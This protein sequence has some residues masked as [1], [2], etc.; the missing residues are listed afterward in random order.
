VILQQYKSFPTKSTPLSCN[1]SAHNCVA[2]LVQ[3][4][5]H[6]SLFL[7]LLL[8]PHHLHC[9]AVRCLAFRR[10]LAT[11]IDMDIHA[12]CYL[13]P[14][15]RYFPFQPATELS[16][17][18]V[19]RMRLTEPDSRCSH[20]ITILSLLL[21]TKLWPCTLPCPLT[22][23]CSTLPPLCTCNSLCPHAGPPQA[24]VQIQY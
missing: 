2:L 12:H 19:V 6:S 20:P 17:N 16:S 5:T 4:L 9:F 8:L 22:S 1:V 3:P 18:F 14:S 10:Q 24:Y 21:C 7:L 13:Q 23:S 11:Y 15:D